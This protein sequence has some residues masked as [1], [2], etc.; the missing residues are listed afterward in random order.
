MFNLHFGSLTEEQQDQYQR[1]CEFVRNHVEP[2]ADSWD[3]NQEVPR[4]IIDLCGKNG[5][6]GGIIPGEYGGSGW[7]AVTFGLLNEAFGAASSSLCA[8]FT[9]QT[10]VAMV[11]A[12]WGTDEQRDR[13]LRSMAS[14][15]IIAS[16][17]LTEPKVG[18][19]IQ[20]IECTFTPRGDIYLLTGTKKW[21]TYS[22]IADIFLVFG[23]SGD[24]S[25]S[26]IVK[27][28]APGVKV[29]PLED[30]LGFRGAHLSQ[31]EFDHCEIRRKDL[32]GKPGF[33]LTYVAPYGLHYG[34]MSTAW[35]S[36]GLLRAC[37]EASVTYASRRQASG[38]PLSDH[39]MIQQ[40]VTDMGVDLEAAWQLC[41]TASRAD[42]A[43]LSGAIAGTL[44]AKY[45]ASRASTRAAA[46][47]VQIMGAAGCHE[48]N[49]AARYYRDA[50]IM[51]IIEGTNQVLQKILGKNFCKKYRKITPKPKKKNQHNGKLNM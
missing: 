48:E 34:R 19:D 42:D 22:A 3:K 37:V 24:Q 46:N 9:V 5:F 15:G 20:A 1:F 35:S 14:G 50:K 32:V 16:F 51:E 7:D 28:D 6:V 40:M 31:I 43:H 45:F 2:F 21:I 12:K 47:T 36:A 23:K 17:A 10:M 18:S 38:V 8:L 4:D 13:W 26:C 44:A 11:L 39:G 41:L 29:T 49:P 27:A 30:M 33:S 25:M